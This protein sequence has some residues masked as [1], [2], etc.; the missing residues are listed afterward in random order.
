MVRVERIDAWFALFG[1]NLLWALVILLVGLFVANLLT[2]LFKRIMRR[3]KVDEGRISLMTIILYAVV[4]V[5][6]V[7]IALHR[8]GFQAISIIRIVLVVGL[9]VG[10]ITLVLR[11]YY[12]S[13]PFKI[14][15]TVEVGG[16]LGKVEAITVLNTRLRTFDGKTIFVPN[17]QI[18]NDKIINYLFTP[19]RRIGLTVCIGYNEDLL[20]AKAVLAEILAEDPS[21]LDDPASRVF[22][23]ELGE[24]SV[25]LAVRAWVKNA[26]YFRTRCDLL[27]KI[28]LRFDREG[29]RF[30]FPQRDVHLYSETAK[31]DTPGDLNAPAEK[32]G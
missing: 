20:K 28:K 13:L 2:M 7:M 22:V 6:T 26:I 15:D 16:L 10:L 29:I 25:D 9:A 30:A 1:Q 32:L 21:V 23:T 11:R 4:V 18:L 19:N 3:A 27:E 24:S 14:E 5:F 8:L 17:R 31:A 12:P